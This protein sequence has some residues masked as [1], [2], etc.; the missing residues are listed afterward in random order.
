[1]D[2]IAK[3]QFA[4]HGV[5]ILLGLTAILGKLTSIAALPLVVYRTFI[6]S[7]I[8]GL[9]F[10]KGIKSDFNK[11]SF[12]W[13]I[14]TGILLGSHWLCFF[15]SARMA[16]ASLSLVTFS[17]TSFFTSI[18]EPISKKERISQKEL[19][20]GS[21][22]FIGMV[23]IFS[24]ESVHVYAILVGL[25]GAV[26]A[27]LYSVSNVHL[28][29]KNGAVYINFVELSAAFVF[30]LCTLIGW[31]MF[32]K[33]PIVLILPSDMDYFYI[34]TLGIICTVI[35]YLVLVNLLKTM[36]AFS[37][38]MAINMEPIYGILLAWLVFGEAEKMSLGFYIG[39][40]LIILSLVLN[41]VWKK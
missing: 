36:T 13:L 1:M 4:L 40:C 16:T 19:L 30:T 11:R 24:F 9:F 38:N 27:S 29:K 2:E 17:T 25:F 31:I 22:V 14:F 15:G 5:V 18:M 33:Q 37:V 26:L 28:A 34:A 39:A 8:I 10:W 32:N 20:L 6:A 41:G 35:P 12:L 3:K 23:L 21:M 7:L